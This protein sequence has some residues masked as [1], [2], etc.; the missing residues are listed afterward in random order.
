[1][2]DPLD[3]CLAIPVKWAI[4]TWFICCSCPA[5]SVLKVFCVVLLNPFFPRLSE[6]D[7]MVRAT[8]GYCKHYSVYNYIYI[9]KII[10]IIPI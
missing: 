2:F 1:M 8:W 9:T 3:H 6:G 5:F 7:H 4:V 10:F